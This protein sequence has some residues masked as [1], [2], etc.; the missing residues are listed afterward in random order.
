M[1]VPATAEC[2]NVTNSVA[3]HRFHGLKCVHGVYYQ[4]VKSWR[5]EDPLLF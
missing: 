1:N 3:K 2:A 5:S 4:I